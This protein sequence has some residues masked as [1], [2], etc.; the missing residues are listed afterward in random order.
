ATARWWRTGWRAIAASR[1][2]TCGPTTGTEELGRTGLRRLAAHIAAKR[3]NP[4]SAARAQH[5]ELRALRRAGGAARA[6]RRGRELIAARPQRAAAQAAGE[7]ERVR[8]GLTGVLEAAAHRHRPQAGAPARRPLRR[9]ALAAAA[10][11]AHELLH[12][13]PHAGRCRERVAHL[14]A[15]PRSGGARAR[16]AAAARGR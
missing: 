8:A 14:R 7:A 4:R 15:P 10:P 3:R 6:D 1:S 12:P 2:R 16:D 11:A 5:P 9:D 13:E